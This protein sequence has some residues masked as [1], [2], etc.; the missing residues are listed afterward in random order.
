[1]GGSIL[2]FARSLFEHPLTEP[3]A[4]SLALSLIE[5][6]FFRAFG[7]HSFATQPNNMSMPTP[8]SPPSLFCFERE[9]QIFLLLFVCFSWFVVGFCVRPFQKLKKCLFLFFAVCRHPSLAVLAAY[10]AAAA[11]SPGQP[12][13]PTH[14]QRVCVCRKIVRD[15]ADVTPPTGGKQSTLQRT[16]TL[17]H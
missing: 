2:S 13:M 14:L 1:M 5:R 4:L 10:V 17:N 16:H 9:R 3:L 15:T 8:A 7:G 12:T 11:A 6:V